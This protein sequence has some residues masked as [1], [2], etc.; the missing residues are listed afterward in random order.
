MKGFEKFV[1]GI[2]KEAARKKHPDSVPPPQPAEA[3]ELRLPEEAPEVV[4]KPSITDIEGALEIIR[5][6]EEGE[7]DDEEKPPT[8]H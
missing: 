5:R 6:Q 7:E 8:V 1:S 3:P 4:R 2:K